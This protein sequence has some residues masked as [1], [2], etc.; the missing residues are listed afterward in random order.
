MN[1]AKTRRPVREHRPGL[2]QC[3]PR[4]LLTTLVTFPHPT[5]P[6]QHVMPP[7]APVTTPNA[8]V[9]K[10]ATMNLGKMVGDGQCATLAQ[11]AVQAAGGKPF[12]QLG[13]TGPGADYVWGKPVT[14]LTATAGST[15]GILPGDI[16]QFRNLS[17]TET[18]K[19]TFAN[20]G[21]RSQSMTSSYPHHTAI[22]SSVNGNFITVLEQNVNSVLI[23]QKGTLWA[24]S[25]A[26]HVVNK[27]GSK[28]DTTYT[29]NGGTMW[30]YRPFA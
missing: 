29:V 12:Y 25:S 1:I 17:L 18:V 3:E 8:K 4:A 6:T 30:V 2:D 10:F 23:D 14:T 11:M 27:D 28:T 9:L 24:H 15:A 22:V 20:G 21:W 7:T 19:T 16:I 13:P 5:A 26:T